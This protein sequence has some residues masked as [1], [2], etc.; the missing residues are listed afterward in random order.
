M[1]NR[2]PIHPLVR[3]LRARRIKLGML[4]RQVAERCGVTQTTV[5]DWENGYRNPNIHKLQCWAN[6]LDM[7]LALRDL[8]EEW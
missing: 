5:T 3:Q 1:V 7:A 8:E 6:A 4:Q 2:R